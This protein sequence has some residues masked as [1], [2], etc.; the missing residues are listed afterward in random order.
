MLN[1]VEEIKQ[2]EENFHQAIEEGFIP[3][4]EDLA[5]DQAELLVQPK[6]IQHHVEEILSA[7]DS[8]W[9]DSTEAFVGLRRMSEISKQATE[10]LKASVEEKLEGNKGPLKIMN[11]EIS[12]KSGAVRYKYDHI[13]EIQELK[14]KIKKLEEKAKAATLAYERGDEL[15]SGKTGE[16]I[17]MAEKVVSKSS[18]VVK[19]LDK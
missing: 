17:P 12:S 13:P 19:L 11:A 1:E 15:Y 3:S 6:T 7:V 10:R 8:G 4:E 14:E 16:Q 2:S 5:R 9:L 18:I